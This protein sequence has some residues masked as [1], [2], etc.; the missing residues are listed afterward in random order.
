MTMEGG[1]RFHDNHAE[2]GGWLYVWMG[3]TAV[4]KGGIEVSEAS[5]QL[6]GGGAF[7]AHYSIGE[8]TGT[9]WVD[10]WSGIGAA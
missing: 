4:V 3:V 2:L 10:C 8:F 7:F 5:A 9:R 6:W 1:M